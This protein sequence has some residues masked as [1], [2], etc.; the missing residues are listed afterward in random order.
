MDELMAKYLATVTTPRGIDV[1]ATPRITGLATPQ[2][3]QKP[4]SEPEPGY[5]VP[6]VR[7]FD[8]SGP[9]IA[10][11]CAVFERT[12]ITE[13][14]DLS[15]EASVERLAK[16]NCP[17]VEKKGE[18]EVSFTLNIYP[19]DELYRCTIEEDQFKIQVK[20]ELI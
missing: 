4:E 1:T 16:E 11:P 6:C 19:L 7:W 13:L 18:G 10:N 9:I 8:A 17:E 2:M 15:D 20:E 14:F 3:T 5:V 12:T